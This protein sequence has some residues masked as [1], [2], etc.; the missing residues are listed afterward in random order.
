MADLPVNLID[1]AVIIII[2]ISGIVAF[3]RGFIHESLSI[4][5]WLGGIAIAFFGSFKVKPYLTPYIQHEILAQILG[6]VIV[7]IIAMFF[8]SYFASLIAGKVKSSQLN[9]VD[10]SLGFLFGLLRGFVILVLVFMIVEFVW[11]A[12]KYP[13]L[14]KNAKTVPLFE[15]SSN[16][17]RDF[18]GT[19]ISNHEESKGQSSNPIQAKALEATKKERERVQ[20]QQNRQKIQQAQ[21]QSRQAQRSTQANKPVQSARMKPAQKQI[22]PKNSAVQSGG[23]ANMDRQDLENLFDEAQ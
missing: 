15:K 8:L 19:Y 4:L 13:V 20:A 7:F 23:Y 5:G 12:D 21:S 10:R 6:G 17:L 1:I 3:L 9:A 11:P 14:L 22:A 2:L 16:F 18:M